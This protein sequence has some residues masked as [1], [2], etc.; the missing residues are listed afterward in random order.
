[1]LT[2]IAAG[3][4]LMAAQAHAGARQGVRCPS[5][6][7]ATFSGDGRLLCSQAAVYELASVC[8]VGMFTSQIRRITGVTLFPAGV[9]RCVSQPEGLERDSIMAASGPELPPR[10]AF[11]RQV[12]ANGPDKF[13][14]AGGSKFAFPEG[15][16]AYGSAGAS[17]GVSCPV[18]F[19]VSKIENDRGI[20]CGQY[21]G[22]PIEA[23]C[24]AEWRLAKDHVRDEDRCM[25]SGAGHHRATKP[26]G[27]TR[28]QHDLELQSDEK[29]WVLTKR[30]GRDTW[31]RVNYR[32]PQ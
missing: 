28:A 4:E 25:P 12:D 8:T 32:F 21:D 26:T 7:N 1:M 22:V 10:S 27:I 18:D 17:K 3:F 5:G 9:D 15:G 6:F 24:E 16:P 19:Q 11:T 31:Q 30:T 20:R 14:A 13:V 29:S 2:M 23:D